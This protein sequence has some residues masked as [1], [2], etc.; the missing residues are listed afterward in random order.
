MTEFL[1]LFL[2]VL[3]FFALY[4]LG[5]GVRVLI[6]GAAFRGGCG[7]TEENPGQHILN[8]GACPKKKVALC[9]TDDTSGLAGVAKI[10]TMA[11]YEDD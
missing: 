8:C 4:F 1:T 6:K 10:A 5:M 11:R 3:T 2:V 9:E 7:T